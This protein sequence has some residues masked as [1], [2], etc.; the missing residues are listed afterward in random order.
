VTIETDLVALRADSQFTL[1]K[2]L[3]VRF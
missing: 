2:G 3:F 1:V